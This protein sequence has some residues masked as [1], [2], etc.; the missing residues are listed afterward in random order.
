MKQFILVIVSLVLLLSSGLVPKCIAQSQLLSHPPHTIEGTLS[1]GMHYIVLPNKLPRHDIELRLVM[2]VGSLQEQANQHGGAHFLEHMSFAGTKHFPKDRWVDFFE[3][4]GMKY[5]R[6]INAFTG[7]DR[8]IYWLTLPAPISA[9]LMDSTLL[10]VRDVLDGISF[11]PEAINSERGVILEELRGYTTGDDFY[12][13]KIGTGV[14]P[15]HMPLGTEADIKSIGRSQLIDFY[16]RWYLPRYATLVIVGNVEATD[17]EARIKRA[18]DGVTKKSHSVLASHPLTYNKGITIQ[19]QIDENAT[20]QRLELIIPHPTIVGKT[21]ASAIDKERN[22][23]LVRALNARFAA[24]GIKCDVSDAWYL[25]NT[26]HWVFAISGAKRDSVLGGL[27]RAL[28]ECQ[29]VVKRGFSDAEL[30]HYK[31]LAML[32]LKPDTMLCLSTRWVDDFVDYVISGDRYIHTSNDVELVRKGIMQTTSNQLQKLMKV[33]LNNGNNTLLVANKVTANDT[34]TLASTTIRSLW[35]QA[36]KQPA[37]PYIYKPKQQEKDDLAHSFYSPLCI[38]TQHADVSPL[39]V[40][41]YEDLSATEYTL[42]NGLTLLC[43]RTYEQDSTVHLSLLSRGGLSDLSQQQYPLLK[44][45]ASYVDMGGLA[46]VSA[47]TLQMLMV[48]HNLS[49][50]IGIDSYWHQLLA[51]SPTVHAQELFNLVYEKLTAPGRDYKGFQESHKEELATYGK[52]SYLERMLERDPDR[53]LSRTLDSIVGNGGVY[54]YTEIPQNVAEKV[55]LDSLTTYYTR[56]FSNPRQT[57]IVLTGNFT[58]DVV[59]KAINTFACLHPVAADTLQCSDHAYSIELHPFEKR[60][61]NSIETQSV[62]NVVYAG[63]YSPSLKNTLTFKLM[64]DLLQDRMLSIL[65]KQ[66][67]IVYSPYA[68]LY[69]TGR[70]QQVYYF[71]LTVAVKKENREIALSA[72]RKVVTQLQQ[73]VVDSGELNKMKRAFQVNKRKMLSDDAAAEWKSTLTSLVRNGESIAD[74]DHYDEILQSITPNDIRKAFQ[75]YI[76]LENTILLTKE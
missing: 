68:D 63:N 64:R 71:W 27:Q 60:F 32:S 31:Q 70:P 25:A 8:T 12:N 2:R 47:D 21:I 5:G 4:M 29:N 1:N 16:N 46:H 42:P 30:N 50:S 67:N 43:R 6:D 61:E 41:H 75:Q 19:T 45:A 28:S 54:G 65:R 3:R 62:L 53:M 24:G 55:N 74:F 20:T 58:D 7:F 36:L 39:R 34:D 66:M 15:Q 13:L 44:D 57:I 11:E 69:Y 76:K 51:S 37:A 23:M 40:Q 38:A 10:A 52:K 33:L 73:N 14:Y 49:M 17:I 59:K 56:L 18:F 26:N 35:K 22:R 72:L 9:N 48:D